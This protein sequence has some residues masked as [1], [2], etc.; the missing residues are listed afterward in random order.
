MAEQTLN[1]KQKNIQILCHGM[2]DFEDPNSIMDTAALLLKAS[3]QMYS[4]V[5]PKHH[6]HELL[7]L[8]KLSLDQN[9]E[10]TVYH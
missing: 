2:T 4:V 10:N 7:D 9:T 8:A 3:M 1:L 6:M 5:L